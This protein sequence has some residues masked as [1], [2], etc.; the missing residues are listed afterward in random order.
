M[1]LGL[2]TPVV[3]QVPG[4]ASPWEADAGPEELRRV[5]TTA[6]ELGYEFLTCSE[7]VAIPVDEAPARGDVYWDPLSTL[8]FLA[9]HTRRIKLTTAVV[10]LG[11]HHPL[12]IVKRYGTLDRLSAGRL[13]LG[14]GIGSLAAEFD[15]IGAQWDQRAA[16]ADDALRAL[17]AS[18]SSPKPEYHG[19][20]YSFGGMSVRPF[21]SAARVPI[22]VGG[23]TTQSLRRAIALADGWL[24]FALPV[25]QVREML[26]A[27]DPPAGFDVVLPTGALDPAAR[28]PD[29]RNR[30]ETLREAGATA[31]SC[32]LTARSLEHYLEQLGLLR[33]IADTL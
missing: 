6:D 19:P 32:T 27:A 11:Y 5:A 13:I 30:L 18:L 2:S 16:R 4:V 24:P 23:R 7:H 26:A 8:G 28:G 17:R 12:E 9:A 3:V 14:V 21:A 22:W 25:R 15:L 1:R 10:V 20:H 33:D 31:V 29:V